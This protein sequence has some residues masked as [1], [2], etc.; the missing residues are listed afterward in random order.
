MPHGKEVTY[1]AKS[2]ISRPK[3]ASNRVFVVLEGQAK[4]CIYGAA[5]EQTLGIL[6]KNNLYV[7]HTPAWVESLSKCTIKSWPIQQ[8]VELFKE[9]PMLAV[10]VIS[11]IGGLLSHAIEMIEDLA[12]RNVE[13]RLA[14]YLLTQSQQATPYIEL[15][16][17]TELV[18][19]MLGTS[20]QT[21]S[22]ILT[23]LTKREVIE[24]IDARHLRLL[25]L[26]QLEQLVEPLSSS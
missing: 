3:E 26:Q 12:F 20:R 1:P 2:T 4:I 6:A 13:S 8:V 14:R 21:L 9:E 10:Q 15:P 24:R 16:G 18:A 5:R 25:D 11:E 7:T 19:H 17:S 23:V 22:S